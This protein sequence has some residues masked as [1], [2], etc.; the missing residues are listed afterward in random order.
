MGIVTNLSG[1]MKLDSSVSTSVA[2]TGFYTVPVGKV[3]I[4]QVTSNVATTSAF[5]IGGT[6]QVNVGQNDPTV[7]QSVRIEM[8]DGQSI[9]CVSNTIRVSGTLYING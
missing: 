3:F 1:G 6:G 8:A 4:G 7:T 2:A 9:E 5:K